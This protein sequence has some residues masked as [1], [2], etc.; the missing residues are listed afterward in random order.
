MFHRRSSSQLLSSI[1]PS[2]LLSAIATTHAATPLT[3]SGVADR[4]T[5]TDSVQFQ[6]VSNAG[7]SYAV[8]LNGKPLPAGV[9][10]T[11]SVMDYYDLAVSR[12]E[13]ATS[14]T[15]NALVRFIVLSSNRG[16]P[17]LGLI[18]WTPYPPIP[19]GSGEFAGGQLHVVAPQNYPMGLE[20]P[21][22]AWVDD[23]PGNARRVN[24]N[25]TA[26]GFAASP[27]PLRRGVGHAFLPA[28]G[29]SGPITYEAQIQSLSTNK[30]INIDSSTTWSNVSGI[31]PA[32]S[33]WPANSRIR[34]TSHITISAG[35]TLTI[36]AGAIVLLNPSVNITNSGRTVINGTT[37]QPVVFTAA[38]RVAPEQHT[39]A[40][41]G[42]LLRGASAELIANGTIITGAGASSGFSFSPGASHR[43]EQA[44]LL[45]HSGARLSMTNCYVINN[46]GQIGNGL[47]SDVTYDHCLLQRAITCGEYEGGTVIINNSAVIEFPS[48]D[49]EY[50]A[51]IAD[52]DYDGIYFTTGTHI[53]QNS[54][55]GF[56]KDDAIDSGSG[57][58]GTMVVSNCWVES[59][60]HEAL[61]WSGGGRRTWSYDSVLIN[62]G[63]GIECGWS[64][65][66]DSPLCHGARLLSLGNSVGARYGDN[67]TGTTGLGLKTGFLTV[68]NSIVLN[69]Y[70]DVWGQV[71][72]DTWN[73]RVNRMDIHDNFITA[74]N[75]NHPNNTVW[76]PATHA[77]QLLAFMRTPPGAAVGIGFANWNAL[78]LPSLTNGIP[79]R[80]S[81]FTTNFVSFA[82]EVRTPTAVL[83]SGT[84]IFAP[85]ET[86]K[87]IYAP[88]SGLPA[89]T[90]VRV[91]LRDP[92]GGEFTTAS[93][94]LIAPA[95]T[96]V[97]TNITLLS[98][99]SAW[100]YLDNGSDQ[101]T[102][103]RAPA[104]NDSGWSNGVAQLGYGDSPVDETTFLR[105]T[106]AAGTTNITFYFR[107]TIQIANPAQFVA[108]RLRLLRDDAGVV[109]VN[110][111]EI[112]RS[113]NLPA[114]PTAINY[115]T[116]ATSTGENTIDSA[117]L[118][119]SGLVAGNNVIAVEIHQES[120]GSSDVS[121]DLELTGNLPAGPPRLNIVRFG[122]EIV[123]FWADAS[124]RLEGSDALGLDANW[125][126]VSGAASPVTLTPAAARQFY[127]LTKP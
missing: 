97:N 73:Y 112:F 63:Q 110:G 1:L 43:S 72:D 18:Q 55:F 89:Q 125:V 126:T 23:G 101:V 75:T 79:I 33:V 11:V 36:E 94:L 60:L 54:L 52:A 106:N 95:D 102:A 115:L 31:L 22:V 98:F 84:L 99:N 5:Y 4:A 78:T 124:Y 8:T 108:L 119:T 10:H 35:D 70:R 51:T 116:R 111:G 105:R 61:A 87:R 48:I 118:S 90:L 114:F 104:F 29:N 45:I 28:A 49:G 85:G 67:Y 46:A 13:T 64:T 117:T 76:N 123:L 58:A 20:I 47:N 69:N 82:Y 41:G 100:K 24:G 62:C 86:V 34:V 12:T 38:T 57:G 120:I 93:Q 122:D 15:T 77:G 92:V 121:F 40:W 27:L 91:A 42:F 39:G 88:I 6:V 26:P 81:T 25:V 44:V 127:R 74:P 50:N 56:A 71:W 59:A 83:A 103:W 19:S 17:E 53:L 32:G 109:Y 65:G 107:K 3:I 7:F 80:L 16:S 68:T 37:E 21:I 66:A 2:L 30:P 9:A 113:P 14:D 96:S